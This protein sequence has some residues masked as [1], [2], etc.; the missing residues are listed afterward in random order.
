MENHRIVFHR[1]LKWVKRAIFAWKIVDL[2]EPLLNLIFN[3][4]SQRRWRDYQLYKS[5]PVR[6]W[7]VAV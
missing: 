3:Y 6:G 4:L 2:L 7:Q 5:N 1:I